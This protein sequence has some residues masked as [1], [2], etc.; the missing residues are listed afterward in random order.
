MGSVFVGVVDG[1]ELSLVFRDSAIVVGVVAREKEQVRTARF[2]AV[3]DS[4]GS[5]VA[6]STI[7]ENDK[8]KRLFGSLGCG[9]ASGKDGLLISKQPILEALASLEPVQGND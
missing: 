6:I 7:A 8:A 5:L 9:G 4:S 3:R 2:D 1:E